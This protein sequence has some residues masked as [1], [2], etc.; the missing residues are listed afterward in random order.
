MIAHSKPWVTAEDID[1]INNVLHS[2]M[3][4]NGD[5][6]ALF[7][8]QMAAYTSH[9]YAVSTSS[10]R[11]ALILAL[12]MLNVGK[13]DQVILPS[14]VCS[15]V[16][17][18]ILFLGAQPIFCDIGENWCMTKE[19]VV[20]VITK[21]TKA[22][23]GVHIFGIA[24]DIEE[25]ATL[26]IPVI[27][28]SC[29]YLCSETGKHA[30]FTILSFHATKC[31][32]T[33]TGGMLLSRHRPLGLIQPY[34]DRLSNMQAALGISQLHKYETMLKYR[35]A[36]AKIYDE[37]IP[38]LYKKNVEKNIYFRYPI[39]V[40]SQYEK[41]ASIFQQHG[42]TVRRGV[43]ALLHRLYH[44]PDSAFPNSLTRYNT[45]ISIPIYPALTEPEIETITKACEAALQ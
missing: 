41:V 15:S 27:E 38:A 19:N 20:K 43:D 13:A 5:I 10:G 8:E 4:A 36:I 22:I 16:L 12:T 1:A 35:Q 37:K 11:S 44:L 17:E 31:L 26:G 23:I 25:I 28:D 2:G 3:I 39:T 7:E 33:G 45:T 6:T 9:K 14:Y 29:Q 32:S 42:V 40:I 34:A 30:D 24:C 21:D 18:A